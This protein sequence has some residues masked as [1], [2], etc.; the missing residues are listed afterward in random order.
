MIKLC[1]KQLEEWIRDILISFLVNLF[2]RV[3]SKQLEESNR[4]KKRNSK[5]KKEKLKEEEKLVSREFVEG[6][7]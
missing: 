6:L 2:L 3:L 7:G 1:A 5:N 4:R